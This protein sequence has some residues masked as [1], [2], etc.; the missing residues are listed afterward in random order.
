MAERVFITLGSN[1]EPEKNLPQAVKLLSAE[2]RI[3]KASRVY[4]TAPVGTSGRNFLNAAVLVETDTPPLVL[5]FEILRP[6]EARLGRVRTEDKNAPRPIDLDVALYGSLILDDPRNGIRLPDP[7][8]LTRAHVALPLADLDPDCI[9]PLTDETLAQIAA[10]LE[11]SPG[12]RV[13]T[14]TLSV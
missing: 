10:R 5:K 9:H 11:H 8:I 3:L 6:I 12:V 7:D 4:E 14:L 1:I 13:H 2:V